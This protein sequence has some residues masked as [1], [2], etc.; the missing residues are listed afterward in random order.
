MK[1][2]VFV[3]S[4]ALLIC[5]AALLSCAVPISAQE[6]LRAAMLPIKTGSNINHWWSGDFDPGAC[7]TELLN[8]KLANSKRFTLIDKENLAAIMEEH[9]LAIAGEVTAETASKIGEL[10]GAKYFISGTVIEFSEVNTGGGSKVALGFGIGASGSSKGNKKVRVKTVVKITDTDSRVIVASAESMK[11]IPVASGGGSFYIAGTGG[12]SEG[13]E[14]S[15]S[16][17][18]KGMEEVAV[19]LVAKLESA[20]VKEIKR[21]VVT[22]YIM[23]VDGDQI[24]IGLDKPEFKDVVK[25]GYS[26]K[27]TREK[28][29]KDPKSLTMRTINR[30]VGDLQV[31]SVDG[32]VVICK[33]SSTSEPVQKN[34]K[35]V[36]K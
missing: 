2:T 23:D 13:G 12:G 15:A 1:N 11:E 5:A 21:V 16:G 32:D 22:G 29:I 30:P 8:V 10:T 4:L 19:D 26:F 18:G 20:N 27:V 36:T 31:M 35:V 14:T 6:P 24:Y 33:A 9:N 3:L 17:L 25:K 34:D 7:M 28:S